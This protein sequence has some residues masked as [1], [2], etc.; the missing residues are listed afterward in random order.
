MI[1]LFGLP[2]APFGFDVALELNVHSVPPKKG[3]LLS[4]FQTRG[5]D[6]CTHAFSL[7]T[8]KSTL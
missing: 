8:S 4:T 3:E 6:W 1:S 7:A 2:P 5:A